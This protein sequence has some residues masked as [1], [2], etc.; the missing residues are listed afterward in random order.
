MRTL[1]RYMRTP[2]PAL[3]EDAQSINKLAQILR[4]VLLHR[5]G[6]EPEG[7]A[8]PTNH[9]RELESQLEQRRKRVQGKHRLKKV[10]G[11][12]ASRMKASDLGDSFCCC[13]A[14]SRHRHVSSRWCR[15]TGH[16]VDDSMVNR[17]TLGQHCT[18][19]CRSRFASIH[20]ISRSSRHFLLLNATHVTCF[21]ESVCLSVCLSVC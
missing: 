21:P 8:P 10:I 16:G 5:K 19:E 9:E 20:W 7:P 12:G 14:P 4:K 1:V 13:E 18:A 17:A 2:D 6:I 3:Q 11:S 15:G